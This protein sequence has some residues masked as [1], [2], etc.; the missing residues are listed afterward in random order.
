MIEAQ[1]NSQEATSLRRIIRIASP[2]IITMV[3]VNIMQFADRTFLARYDL[4]HFTASMPAGIYSFALLSVFLGITGFVANLVAQYY[5]ARQ[6]PEC[7]R[8]TWQGVYFSLL[9]GTLLLALSPAAVRLFRAVGHAENL[10]PLESQYFYCMIVSGLFHLLGNSLAGFFNGIGKTRIPMVAAVI[11]NGFNILM[12]WILIFG[13]LGMPALGILG[14]GIASALGGLVS[15]ILLAAIFLSRSNR[16]NYGTLRAHGIQRGILGKLLRFGMP[17]G[18]QFFLDM[19]ALSI[20]VLLI[21]TLGEI[22]LSAT[23]MAFTIESVAFMPLMGLSLGVSIIAGQEMGA[24]RPMNVYKVARKGIAVGVVFNTA[25]VFVFLF[26]PDVLMSVFNSGREIEKFSQIQQYA[27]P[28]IQ[29]A[30]AWIFFDAIAIVVSGTLRAVGDTV[31]LMATIGILSLL[32]IVIPS[33]VL[34]AVLHKPVIYAWLLI[35]V[36]VVVLCFVFLVRFY[37]GKWEK[38]QVM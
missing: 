2:A 37:R 10:I 20:F 35:V 4:A 17:A 38:I 24:R 21:G 34:I 1:L 23:N 28:L 19:A 18:V 5:G 3:S 22:E 14:A 30:A 31:F 15:V 9:C 11:A 6:S 33:Y 25:L 36:Y 8:A 16:S 27:K 32:I 26:L 29:L 7:A 12:N 13:K